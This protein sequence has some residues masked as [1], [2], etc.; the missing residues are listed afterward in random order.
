MMTDDRPEIL[1]VGAGAQGV[2]TGYHLDLAGARVTFLVREGRRAA[3]Q[4]GQTLY[5]YDDGGSLKRFDHYD[6]V[7]D[8]K[9]LAGRRFAYVL[10]TLDGASCRSAE[11]MALLAAL[12]DLVRGTDA[13][14]I[15]GGVGVRDLFVRTMALPDDRVLEGTLGSLAYQT[16][17]VTLPLHPPTDPAELAKSDIAYHHFSNRTGFMMAGRPKAA[18]E[19]FAAL[20]TRSGVSK[21]IVMKPDVFAIMSTAFFPMTAMCDL[22]GWPDAAT[23]IADKPLMRL[24]AAA[25][26]EVIALPGHGWMGRLAAPVMRRATLG[27]VLK[28]MEQD[29]LPLDFHAFNAFHHG[30]KVREQDIDVMKDCIATGAAAGRRMTALRELVSRYERHIAAGAT[31]AAPAALKAVA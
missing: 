25:M 23:M 2:V 19:R 13:Y 8:A 17:R 11:G 31:V 26:R 18:A 24:G 28:K 3:L 21:G 4:G 29:S 7:T 20:H 9:A 6:V 5:C 1:I 15:A 10:V 16:D 14:V 27:M 12:G 30:G 22:A